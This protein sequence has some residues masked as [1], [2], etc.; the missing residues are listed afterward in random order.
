MS[1]SEID[2]AYSI[3]ECSYSAE[4]PWAVASSCATAVTIDRCGHSCRLGSLMSSKPSTHR[5]HAR[6]PA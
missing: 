2:G 1:L 3:V 4:M 5:P 6:W